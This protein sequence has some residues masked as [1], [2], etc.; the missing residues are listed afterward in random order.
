[1]WELFPKL[2]KSHEL[3]PEYYHNIRS[4]VYLVNICIDMCIAGWYT[5]TDHH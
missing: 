1:M 4:L 5:T 3:Y 2:A